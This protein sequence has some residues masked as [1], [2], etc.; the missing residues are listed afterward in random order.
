[1]PRFPGAGRSPRA[2]PALRAAVDKLDINRLPHELNYP[3]QLNSVL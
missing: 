1:V 3:N 2:T